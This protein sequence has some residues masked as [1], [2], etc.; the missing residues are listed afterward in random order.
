MPA[1]IITANSTAMSIAYQRPELSANVKDIKANAIIIDIMKKIF[2]SRPAI[3][4]A[5]NVQMITVVCVTLFSHPAATQRHYL[6]H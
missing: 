4:P 6:E 3:S 1:C 2:N 5:I